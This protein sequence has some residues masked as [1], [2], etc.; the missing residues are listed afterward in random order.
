MLRK[1][2]ILGLLLMPTL[3]FGQNTSAPKY[4]P[5]RYMVTIWTEKFEDFTV[6]ADNEVFYDNYI[7]EHECS[8]EFSAENLTFDP[9]TGLIEGKVLGQYLI[10][11]SNTTVEMPFLGN[12]FKATLN[13]WGTVRIIETKDNGRIYITTWYRGILNEDKKKWWRWEMV[14][15]SEK[16]TQYLKFR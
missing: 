11:V 1:L 2:V 15:R 9:D 6:V 12:D 10:K 14:H 8:I 5:P 13:G 7:H 4:G 16:T 3:A